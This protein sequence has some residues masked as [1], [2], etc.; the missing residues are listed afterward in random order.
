MSHKQRLFTRVHC[1]AYMQK[2]SDGVRLECWKPENDIISFDGQLTHE[3]EKR[4]VWDVDDD[5]R[6]TAVR[7]VYEDGEW[8]TEHLKD[9][10]D[11][12]GSGVEKRYRRRVEEEFDG[13]LVGI[14]RVV[15]TGLIGTDYSEQHIHAMEFGNYDRYY[16]HLFK[17]R[18]TEKVGV[19][20]FKNNCKRYVLLDDMEEI[21]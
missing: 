1:R 14:T 13:F 21:T 4:S 9:L 2:Y 8:R 3:F 11:F 18:N 15:T 5:V 7:D 20:Y 17:N 16:H 10:S 19:V 12:E 6:V